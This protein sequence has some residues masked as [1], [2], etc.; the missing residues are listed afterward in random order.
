MER[1]LC[2]IFLA[3]QASSA[4]HAQAV[5]NNG[6]ERAINKERYVRL[7]YGNDYFTATDYYLTQTILL[8][9]AHPA[10]RKNPVS[11][12]LFRPATFQIKYGLAAEHNGY[13]PTDY[14][15]AQILY[16]DRPFAGA[17][18][19]KSFAIAA[20]T[21]RKQRL[22]SSLSIGIIGPGAGAG[23]MQT[24]IH[25]RT[26]NA[27]PEGWPNQIANDLLLN[28]QLGYEKQILQAA[29]YFHVSATALAKLGTVSTKANAGL[30]FMT[31]I[32]NSP[33]A[34]FRIRNKRVQLYIY[35]HPEVNFVIYDA[36]L[37]GGLFNKNNPYTIASSDVTRAVFRNNWGIVAKL[38]IVY[39]E[40]YQ[41]YMSKE[42]KTGM[43]MRNG[44]IQIGVGL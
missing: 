38:G 15:P 9:F 43:E 26:P 28:Y 16:G 44:G 22:A 6:I 1:L 7:N 17:I 27:I 29:D 8:E 4:V 2:F 33:Y 41:S 35:D 20:D 31:G 5:D 14:V 21:N 34:S 30:T 19:L 24:Y 37:Q 12:I 11:N 36:T 40:Y 32:F 10:L 25:E 18:S 3:V 42:F 13:T 23:E 39:L